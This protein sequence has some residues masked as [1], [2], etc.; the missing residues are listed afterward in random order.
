MYMARLVNSLEPRL[1]AQS[2][3]EMLRPIFRSARRSYDFVSVLV[4]SAWI[5]YIS[6]SG[7][8]RAPVKPVESQTSAPTQIHVV[9][10]WFEEL[11]QKSPVN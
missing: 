7:T 11:K 6:Q 3:K 8:S 4:R 5:G 2:R 9:L 10:N 1:E